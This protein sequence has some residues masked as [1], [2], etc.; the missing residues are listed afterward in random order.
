MAITR[1]SRVVLRLD[2]RGGGRLAEFVQVGAEHHRDRQRGPFL[3]KPDEIAPVPR[4]APQHFA[5][6]MA[7]LC[8]R[9]SPSDTSPSYSVDAI[10]PM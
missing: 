1:A 8:A 10:V 4:V 5:A 9:R 2:R 6:L 3:E 7:W